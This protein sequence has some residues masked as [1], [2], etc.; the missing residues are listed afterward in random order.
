MSKPHFLMTNYRTTREAG[1]R[2]GVSLRTVQ[3]WCEAGTIPFS[4][5]PGGHR[6][7]HVA[8]LALLSF[9][10]TN[11]LPL[12]NPSEYAE[13]R[14]VHDASPKSLEPTV[15]SLGQE[16]TRSANDPV[17]LMRSHQKCRIDAGQP[18]IAVDVR[19]R[20]SSASDAVTHA[21]FIQGIKFALSY[22][23]AEAPSTGAPDG[24]PADL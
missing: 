3:L 13:A 7:I 15:V 1:A 9:R 18:R 14:L 6:R 24:K 10:M 11:A 12:P 4:R 22:L 8:Y 17:W 19:G 2:L 16:L 21:A 20:I 5:T 23:G